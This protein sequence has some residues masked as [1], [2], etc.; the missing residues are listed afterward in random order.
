MRVII[1]KNWTNFPLLYFHKFIYF[2]QFDVLYL[3]LWLSIKTSS[4]FLFSCFLFIFVVAAAVERFSIRLQDLN[5][6]HTLCLFSLLFGSL[7]EF[8]LSKFYF[9]FILKL[10][11]FLL[12]LKNCWN[13]RKKI[14]ASNFFTSYTFFVAMNKK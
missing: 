9:Y 14:S 4:S 5:Y 13:N 2:D 7:R 12:A 6:I 3:L 1:K 11:C 8:T 10:C